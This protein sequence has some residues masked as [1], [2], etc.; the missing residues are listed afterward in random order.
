MKRQISTRSIEQSKNIWIK[1]QVRVAI[2]RNTVKNYIQSGYFDH[3]ASNTSM[4]MMSGQASL[5]I[6]RQISP[7]S[8][9][10]S[11]NIWI[12][13]WIKVTIRLNTAKNYFEST[14]FD[15]LASNTHMG[16]ASGQA[17]FGIKRQILSR[18]IKWSKNIWIKQWVRVAIGRNTVKNYIESTYFDH[19]ASK[20]SMRMMSG[21]ASLSI[22]RYILSR[23]IELNKSIWIK[24]WIRVAIGQN[25]AKNYFESAYFDRFVSSL[26]MRTMLGQADFHLIQ[27]PFRKATKLYKNVQG[28]RWAADEYSQN[29]SAE[30]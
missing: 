6:K 4:R 9:E 17:N 27:Q 1:Q 7:R 28:K 16:M 30:H 2:G 3:F 12:K 18:S 5:G 13:Q 11:K 24:Q 10:W 20:T 22:K 21:Q 14:Y 26:S 23:S 25:T 8:I 15:C 19:F 29:T